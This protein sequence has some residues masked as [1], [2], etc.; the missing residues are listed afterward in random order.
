[1][2]YE[3]RIKGHEWKPMEIRT[4]K[5][6]LAHQCLFPDKAL[7]AIDEGKVYSTSLKEYRR[8]NADEPKPEFR[9]IGNDD[10]TAI[11]Q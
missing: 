4:L 7:R 8:V 10:I 2:K 5:N 3:G 9:G 6:E 1:M 11:S